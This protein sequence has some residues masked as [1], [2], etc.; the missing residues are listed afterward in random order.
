VKKTSKLNNEK[1]WSYVYYGVG[2][3]VCVVR[4]RNSSRQEKYIRTVSW[5]QVFATYPSNL[6]S[7]NP[8]ARSLWYANTEKLELIKLQSALMFKDNL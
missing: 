4:Y 1:R 7:R 2:D 3:Y 6:A 5:R 8:V